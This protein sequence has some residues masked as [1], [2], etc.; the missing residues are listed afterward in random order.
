M[1][2]NPIKS[3]RRNEVMR[4][5]H[6]IFCLFRNVSMDLRQKVGSQEYSIKLRGVR[7]EMS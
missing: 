5:L 6:G 4:G 7:K 3:F 2:L 1:S